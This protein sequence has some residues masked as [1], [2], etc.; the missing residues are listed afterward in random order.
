[1]SRPRGRE[2]LINASSHAHIRR[3]AHACKL[4]VGTDD[5]GEAEVGRGA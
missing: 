3:E 1:M 2:F 4:I 5:E